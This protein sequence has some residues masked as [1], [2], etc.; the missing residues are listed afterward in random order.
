MIIQCYG[1]VSGGRW[2]YSAKDY[3]VQASLLRDWFWVPSI[4]GIS[5]TLEIEIKFY[6]LFFFMFVLKCEDNPKVISGIAFT[7][8]IMSILYNANSNK[9][10]EIGR[11]YYIICNIIANSMMYIIFILM[12]LGIYQLYVGQW[13]RKVWIVVEEVLLI[14]FFVSVFL[15]TSSQLGNKFVVNYGSAF[16][17]FVNAYALRNTTKQNRVFRF[18]AQN[19]FA[20]YLL[21]GVNGYIMLTIF[22][23]L[24][25]P[26]YINLPIVIGIVLFVSFLFRRYVE[27]PI[28]Y[29]SQK[30]I[31]SCFQK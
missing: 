16:L 2:V 31:I 14:C 28:G 22:Y 13:D 6:V 30:Y 17:L 23:D 15:G 26:M 29:L 9:L 25:M 4:D 11:S 3:V 7:A 8:C 10:L 5:W 27:Q 24:G 21:H 1:L 19:S 12:G 18:F 20:I